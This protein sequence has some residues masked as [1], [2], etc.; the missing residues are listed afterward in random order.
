[1]AAPWAVMAVSGVDVAGCRGTSPER[2]ATA[3]ENPCAEVDEERAS[4]RERDQKRQDSGYD[5]QHQQ[6]S[7]MGTLR[8]V[9]DAT[10]HERY[11]VSFGLHH[12][13]KHDLLYM[14]YAKWVARPRLFGG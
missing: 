11:Y 4:D 2:S 10:L 8:G 6:F 9:L 13:Q 7:Q 5:F 12:T 14:N 3:P 1:M